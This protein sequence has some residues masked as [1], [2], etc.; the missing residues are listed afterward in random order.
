M[1]IVDLIN[2]VMAV[3]AAITLWWFFTGKYQEYRID[4]TRQRLFS[5]RDELLDTAMDGKLDINST[6]YCLCRKTINGMIRYCH[7]LSFWHVLIVFIGFRKQ[8]KEINHNYN[9]IIQK[10]HKD[11]SDEQRQLLNAI[12]SSMSE[13]IL[14]RIICSSLPLMVLSRIIL[15]VIR[16]FNLVRNARALFNTW[17]FPH[18]EWPMA[19]IDLH[20]QRVDSVS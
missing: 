20:E 1:L 8:M 19:V 3:L 10:A 6:A 4:L 5:I 17:F 9:K 16:V 15:V 14:S 18:I 11:L 7:K 13:F 12:Y 2:T